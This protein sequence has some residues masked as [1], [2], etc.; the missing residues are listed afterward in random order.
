MSECI[1]LELHIHCP[2]HGAAYSWQM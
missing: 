1:G 2:G